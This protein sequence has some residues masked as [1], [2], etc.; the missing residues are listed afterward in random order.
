MLYAVNSAAIIITYCLINT[1]KRFCVVGRP[2]TNI[3][4]E[5][6]LKRIC[7]LNYFKHYLSWVFGWLCFINGCNF[8]ICKVVVADTIYYLMLHSLLYFF[9]WSFIRLT[10]DSL[11]FRLF[12][13]IFSLSKWHDK[14]LNYKVLL[15]HLEKLMLS[16][17]LK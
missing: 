3:F 5:F 2:N 9:N 10:L 1:T 17:A 4:N 7:N 12:Y 6:R 15:D 8:N 11:Q 13:F 14:I 16:A